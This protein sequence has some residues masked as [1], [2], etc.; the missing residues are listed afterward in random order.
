MELTWNKDQ[1]EPYTRGSGYGRVGVLVDDAATQG[2]LVA[3]GCAPAAVKEFERGGALLARFFFIQDPDG[4][5]IEM[6][7]C[8][9][10]CQ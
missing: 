3:K 5:K 7:E 10:H 6:L 2:A 4:Y 8:H 9:G 1:A